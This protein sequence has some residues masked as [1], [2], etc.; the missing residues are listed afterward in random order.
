MVGSISL[1]SEDMFAAKIP[2]DKIPF[3]QFIDVLRFMTT[4][5]T[6]SRFGKG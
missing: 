6:L 5:S 2:R 4:P 1:C 3:K